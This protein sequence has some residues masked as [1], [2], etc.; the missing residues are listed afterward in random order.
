MLTSTA[1]R[2]VDTNIDI[3][4][5]TTSPVVELIPDPTPTEYELCGPRVPLEEFNMPHLDSAVPAEKC[6]ICRK[7]FLETLEEKR[8]RA[9]CSAQHVLHEECLD[10]WVNGIAMDNGNASPRDREVICRAREK[11]H[12]G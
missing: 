1:V 3:D 6:V 12:V 2:D 11:R 10:Y 7:V 8:V 5:E 4:H 9:K